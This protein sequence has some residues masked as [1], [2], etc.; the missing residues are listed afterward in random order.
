MNS[1]SLILSTPLEQFEIIILQPIIIF[2][3]DFSFTNNSLFLFLMF[4]IISVFYYLSIYRTTMM[5]RL[6]QY[7]AENVYMFVLDIINQ[8]IGLKGAKYFPFLFSVFNFI[9]FSNILGLIPFGFTVTSHIIVTFLLSLSINLGV[10]FIGFKL[11]GLKFLKLFAPDGAPI[12]LL[13]LIIIIEIVSYILRTFSLSIRL[14]ANMM[15]GHTLLFIICSFILLFLN[16]QF[17]IFGIIPFILLIMIMILEIGIAFLQAYVFTI[18][19]SIYLND[20]INLH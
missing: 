4:S 2:G 6:W 9:L 13:P 15:A 5:P 17:F 7:I 10:T 18:L 20:S 14:F 3:Y 8:Q 12:F 19:V 11:H 16:S 1:F